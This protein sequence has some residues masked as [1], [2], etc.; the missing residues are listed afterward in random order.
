MVE[1]ISHLCKGL[2]LTEEEQQ[3]FHLPE[4][5]FTLAQDISNSCLVAL[6]ALDREVNKGAFKITMS[7]VWNAERGISFKDIGR[8]KFLL[9]FHSSIVRTR[10]LTGQ[11]WSC[12][13]SLIC[14]QECTGRL[15]LK[16]IEFSLE[17]FWIQL[18]DLPFPAMNRRMGEKLGASAGKVIMVD[19]DEKGRA[20]RGV[21]RVKVLLDLSKPLTRGCVINVGD[22]RSWIPFK[23]KRLPPFCYH[24]GIILHTQLSCTRRVSDGSTYATSQLQYGPWLKADP[25]QKPRFHKAQSNSLEGKASGSGLQASSDDQ[26]S[27]FGGNNTFQ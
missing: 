26:G 18:H 1:E 15:A 19:V 3:D 20:W 7:R 14:I 4:E 27:N 6:V 2:K 24:C 10:V 22:S 17:P 5:E 21:L 23:Y 11:P 25:I 16:D 8:N 12:H 9:E 13:R